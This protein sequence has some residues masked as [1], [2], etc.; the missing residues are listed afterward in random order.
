MPTDASLAEELRALRLALGVTQAELA[1]RA[2]ISERAVSDIE[3]G[4]RRTVYRDTA[5]KIAGA[6]ELSGEAAARFEA[7]A[8]GRALRTRPSTAWLVPRTPIFGR[9]AE[10]AAVRELLHAPQTRLLTLT[11]PG[12]V[13][14][15]RIAL[16][17]ASAVAGD[18]QDGV[19]F[20]PLGDLSRPDLVLPAIASA[21]RVGGG[22][23]PASSIA[24]YLRGRHALL[25]LDTFEH[26]LAA[27]PALAAIVAGSAP[28]KL[29]VT[30]RLPL[31]VRA[32]RLL[33]LLP[34][35]E[36][37][38]VAMFASCLRSQ[39]P[40]PDQA[41]DRAVLAEIC[42]RLDGL[43]LALE[44]AAARARLLGPAEIRSH[45]GRRLPL[46]VEGPRDLP[47]RQRSMA[48]TI[49]WSYDLLSGD[50]RRLLEQLSVF[51]GGWTL[52]S[53]AAICEVPGDLLTALGRLVDSSLV[54]AEIGRPRGTRYRMLD[55]VRE[56]AADR[57][58]IRQDSVGLAEL[59]RRHAAH[60]RALAED[61]DAGLRAVGHQDSVERLSDEV[62]NLRSA[63]GWAHA[64]G[65]S[66]TALRMAADMW[67]FWRVTGAFAEGRA[68]LRQVLEMDAGDDWQ[69]RAR[70]L[71]GAGWMALQ[72]GDFEETAARGAELCRW[73]Q[74]SGDTASLRNGLTLL[75]QERLASGEY[76]EAGRHFDRAL[77]LARKTGSTWLLATSSL[78]RSVAALHLG[79]LDLA[80][81]LQ[82]EAESLYRDLGDDRF[83][84]KTR[85][86]QAYL[87]LMKG[88]SARARRLVLAALASTFRLDDS[89][90]VA[91]QLDGLVAVLASEGDSAAAVRLAGLAAVTWESIGASASPADR[92]S[93]DRWLLPA[94]DALGDSAA[95]TLA[96]GRAVELEEA[97]TG[98]LATHGRLLGVDAPP[99]DD[100][101]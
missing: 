101:A 32:E 36:A 57:L 84:A 77:L 11:G 51:A 74:E 23:D 90:G 83:V 26:L 87:A 29:L 30:S 31:N 93:T 89:W 78:N 72:Q 41:E 1:E 44:L 75:G 2:G 39:Q 79:D 34:L 65:D 98:L 73:A 53:A 7:V 52:V 86:Q 61:A 14:K 12:G 13:G 48:A 96:E 19:A 5:E 94:L 81:S 50:D 56:Y 18:F 38:A 4:L 68:W 42:R 66:R 17:T 21:L 28:A 95:A 27:A 40:T 62:D 20:V 45:L 67:M 80:E 71:W 54:Q 37:D 8:R 16:E 22:S 59:R 70:V 10:L 64:A 91:E 9:T 69:L 55:T 47:E 25:I 97:V 76:S 49:A 6:L 3:R 92:R 46:L 63:L 85:L 82:S 33:T 60:F 99:A 35:D 24:D 88:D 100:R 58:A 15:T 43:P